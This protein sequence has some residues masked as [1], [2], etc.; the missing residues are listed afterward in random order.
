MKPFVEL[1]RVRNPNRH[2]KVPLFVSFFS[3][4][5]EKK[6]NKTKKDVPPIFT[7]DTSFFYLILPLCTSAVY[8]LA[9]KACLNEIFVV[10]SNNV[11]YV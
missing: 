7:D 8:T 11:V 6:K 4:L 1:R 9:D 3:S 10:V 2:E 5:K